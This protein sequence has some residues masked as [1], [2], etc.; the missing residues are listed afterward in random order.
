MMKSPFSDVFY[1]ITFKMRSFH[2]CFLLR[3]RMHGERQIIACKKKRSDCLT[4]S[5]NYFLFPTKYSTARSPANS[6]AALLKIRYSFSTL[7]VNFPIYVTPF[8]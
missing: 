6:P 5:K 7:L 4:A 3:I 8:S 1:D 2:L